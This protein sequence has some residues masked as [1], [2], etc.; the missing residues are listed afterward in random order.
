MQNYQHIQVQIYLV[1]LPKKWNR[2]KIFFVQLHYPMSKWRINITM[3]VANY[4]RKH[5]NSS[6]K[7]ALTKYKDQKLNTHQHLLSLAQL[8]SLHVESRGLK[9]WQQQDIQG[10]LIMKRSYF[11]SSTASLKSV[12]SHSSKRASILQCFKIWYRNFLRI[13]LNDGSRR[14]KIVSW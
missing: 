1:W 9:V 8:L 2:E 14:T 10:V 11:P 12:V 4:Q 6:L 5:L 3:H 13:E 7:L